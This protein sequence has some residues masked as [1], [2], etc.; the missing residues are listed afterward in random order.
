MT[1]QAPEQSGRRSIRLK[2]YDYSQPPAGIFGGR[3]SPAPFAL[4]VLRGD[5]RRG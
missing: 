5:L 3:L 2:G 4:R 1:G